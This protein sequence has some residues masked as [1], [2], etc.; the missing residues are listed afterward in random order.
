MDEGEP[1]SM[2]SVYEIMTMRDRLTTGRSVFGECA[3]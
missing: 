3:T 1:N 2:C